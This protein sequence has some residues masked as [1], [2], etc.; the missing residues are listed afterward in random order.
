M[1]N[2][3]HETDSAVAT[4]RRPRWLCAGALVLAGGFFLLGFLFG[5]FIKSSSE[6]TNITPKHNMK[7]FLDE[8]KAENIKKFLQR[9]NSTRGKSRKRDRGK[10]QSRNGSLF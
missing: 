6:A 7:A 9:R 1:W 5:W 3:L 4:A 2:L 8:L 10:F